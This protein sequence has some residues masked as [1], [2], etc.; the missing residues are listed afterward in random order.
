MRKQLTLIAASIVVANITVSSNAAEAACSS[1]TY[2]YHGEN[3]ITIALANE[4]NANSTNFSKIKELETAK[5]QLNDLRLQLI[6]NK[7][8]IAEITSKITELSFVKRTHAD[9]NKHV[10]I[11]SKSGEALNVPDEGKASDYSKALNSLKQKLSSITKERES[12]LADISN[13]TKLIIE[14]KADHIKKINEI[15]KHYSVE[16][17]KL[18]DIIQKESKISKELLVKNSELKDKNE[19]AASKLMIVESV[20]NKIKEKFK[21]DLAQKTDAPTTEVKQDEFNISDELNGISRNISNT[22]D[23]NKNLEKKL[24]E[25][26]KDLENLEKSS[27]DSQIID[28]KALNTLNEKTR[29]LAKKLQQNLITGE[30]VEQFYYITGNSSLNKSQEEYA[31]KI[32]ELA[33]KYKNIEVSIVGRADPRGNRDY[34]EKLAK[35][36]G[37]N[38]KELAIANG[39]SEG[40]ISMTSYVSSNKIEANR[41]MH[42]FDR[43]S[44]VTI[45]RKMH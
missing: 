7:E 27:Q 29:E 40:S 3:L 34:N 18:K 9:E 10:T 15:E 5:Q 44:T 41:E 20:V 26:A 35:S 1:C 32:F 36:R 39:I 14:I 11:D 25:S 37:I 4:L 42:F 24:K 2:T 13:K 28:I 23:E 16:Q 17:N 6:K 45:R 30:F 12:L 31:G 38:I 43:N 19:N 33:S 22:L 8:T 21:P